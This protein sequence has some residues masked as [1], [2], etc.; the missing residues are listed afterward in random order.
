LIGSA[1]RFVIW[2]P[3]AGRSRSATRGRRNAR[4]A[5]PEA[6]VAELLVEAE[7]GVT[8]YA[9]FPRAHHKKIASTNPLSVEQGD[10]PPD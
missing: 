4:T 9:V 3:Q 7:V 1:W 10:P 6:K 5:I 8:A 2:S